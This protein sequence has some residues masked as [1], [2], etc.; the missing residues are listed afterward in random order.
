MIEAKSVEVATRTAPED[1]T[2]VN[3]AATAEVCI[4]CDLRANPGTGLAIGFQTPSG[5]CEARG[6]TGTDHSHRD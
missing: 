3:E 5:V 2:C 6:E 4:E 1:F